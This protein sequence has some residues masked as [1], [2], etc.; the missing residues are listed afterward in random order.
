MTLLPPHPPAESSA[1]AAK[2]AHAIGPTRRHAGCRD[3]RAFH[4]KMIAGKIRQSAVSPKLRPCFA[5]AGS[6]AIE[7]TV[8]SVATALSVAPAMETLDGSSE[9]YANCAG[10]MVAQL[11]TTVPM[12]L[13]TGVIVRL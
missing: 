3:V 7:V 6:A 10:M 9:Q 12:K 11:S 13:L 2:T 1:M 8:L 4:V 5:G